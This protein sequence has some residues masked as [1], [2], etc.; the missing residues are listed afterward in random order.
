MANRTDE[1]ALHK[2]SSDPQHLIPPTARSAVY[3]SIYWNRC[4]FGVCVADVVHL[5]VNLRYLSGLDTDTQRPS[6]FLCLLQKLLQLSP[7]LAEISVFL[8]Q[9][10]FKYARLLA[11]F[12]V[13]LMQPPVKIYEALEPLLS[14][15]RRIIVSSNES[16]IEPPSIFKQ[17]QQDQGDG[18][19][20]EGGGECSKFKLVYV[21]MVV[22]C[23]LRLN[24]LFGIPFPRIP[25]RQLLEETN[26]L[27][28][29]V[30]SLAL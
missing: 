11:A 2:Y 20:E 15:C 24:E 18:E 7:D 5:S 9:R 13:R 25:P 22:D 16:Q 3:A 23:L 4:C 28:P 27:K 14:D 1:Y 6:P 26:Q 10:E 17:Q 30:S 12:Y 8:K 21:D 29:R 19:G